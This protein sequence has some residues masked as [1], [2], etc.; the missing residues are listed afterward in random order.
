MLHYEQVWSAIKV[1]VQETN[2]GGSDH[3]ALATLIGKLDEIASGRQTGWLGELAVQWEDEFTIVRKG[4][5]LLV[6]RLLEFA[7]LGPALPVDHKRVTTCILDHTSDC[8]PVWDVQGSQPRTAC[9]ADD[10][11]LRA[12][13]TRQGI[14]LAHPEAAERILALAWGAIPV[15]DFAYSYVV[16]ANEVQAFVE[17]YIS[18]INQL[19]PFGADE[20]IEIA[21]KEYDARSDAVRDSHH[22]DD[23]GSYDEADF[24][25]SENVRPEYDPSDLDDPEYAAERAVSSG[26]EDEDL[27]RFEQL[28]A[29]DD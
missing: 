10:G 9:M 16:A 23:G 24:T 12:Y 7:C 22:V 20:V 13:C 3:W 11:W 2:E 25:H 27:E 15:E 6:L 17:R 5:E 8:V 18:L 4:D 29:D 1:L 21:S 14:R 26:P 28:Q 19:T